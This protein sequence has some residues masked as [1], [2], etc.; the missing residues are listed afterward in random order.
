[1]LCLRER[2][3]LVI[4]ETLRS[5]PIVFVRCKSSDRLNMAEKRKADRSVSPPTLKRKVQSSTT[6]MSTTIPFEMSNPLMRHAENAVKSFFT[7]TSQKA[8]EKTRWSMANTTLL[9]AH[10]STSP[11]AEQERRRQGRR[12]FAA[13]DL[14][15]FTEIEHDCFQALIMELGRHAHKNEEWQDFQHRR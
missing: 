3:T 7:P 13:F 10:Y 2:A 12:K 11:D 15:G 14:V 5:R 1:M 6:R 8:P 9:V 4:R